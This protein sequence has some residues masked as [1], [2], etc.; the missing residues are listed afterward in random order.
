MTKVVQIKNRAQ[1][2]KEKS[3]KEMKVFHEKYWLN[4]KDLLTLVL[5]NHLYIENCI[6]ELFTLVLPHPEKIIEKSF[7]AKVDSFESLNLQQNSQI[8]ETIRALNKI[9]NNFAHNINYKV[10]SKDLEPLVK[11]IK[12]IKSKTNVKKLKIGLN[13][14]VG[15]LHCL[16]SCYKLFP[17]T[18][19][20]ISQGGIFIRETGYKSKKIYKTIYPNNELMDIL[21]NDLKI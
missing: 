6:D 19:T 16:K 20:C 17:F 14:I 3:I 10:T 7:S 12:K 13:Y 4:S 18:M 9:R 1:R 5:K 15:Y 2:T 11:N 21:E 8:V